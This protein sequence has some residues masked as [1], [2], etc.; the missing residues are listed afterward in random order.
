M[1]RNKFIIGG[2]FILAA[3]VYLIAS[4]TQASAEYFMTVDELNAEGSKAVNKSVRLSGAVLGDTIQYDA[5]TL[6]LTFDVAHVPGDN[7][8]IEAQGGL[9]AVLHEA[10]TDPARA[11][12]KVVYEGVMPDLLRNEAQAIM[13]GRLGEDGVFHAEELLL[14]CPTKYEEAVP[15]QASSN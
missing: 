7:A 1:Q 9:A 11:H 8:E 4:S 12:I 14:K 13:T 6:T 10:A 2:V 15:E 5:S 3:V